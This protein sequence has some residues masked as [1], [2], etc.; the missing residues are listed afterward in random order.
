[1]QNLLFFSQDSNAI[2]GATDVMNYSVPNQIIV[3]TNLIRGCKNSNEILKRFSCVWYFGERNVSTSNL[4]H[5]PIAHFCP[6]SSVCRTQTT[7]RLYTSKHS[8]ATLERPFLSQRDLR[9][10]QRL[11]HKFC[12]EAGCKWLL[13]NILIVSQWFSALE[14]RWN[15]LVCKRLIL[16]DS[17][18]SL[19]IST[20]VLRLSGFC[21]DWL[22]EEECRWQSFRDS[23]HI[24]FALKQPNG[25][26]NTH[27]WSWMPSEIKKRIFD[28]LMPCFKGLFTPKT[29]TVKF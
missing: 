16:C 15:L 13:L 12:I 23:K 7:Y 29:I 28:Y 5:A 27:G 9:V 2:I 10:K 22:P 14:V 18:F 3:S 24:L 20:S 6:L 25:R 8:A 17:W 1:M 21:M 4:C 19:Y 11:C 26:K